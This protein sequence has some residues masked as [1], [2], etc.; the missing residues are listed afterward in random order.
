MERKTLERMIL[1][2]G[3]NGGERPLGKAFEIEHGGRGNVAWNKIG[4]PSCHRKRPLKDTPKD[5]IK[6]EPKNW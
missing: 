1:A 2:K 3:L 5:H 4:K 6:N